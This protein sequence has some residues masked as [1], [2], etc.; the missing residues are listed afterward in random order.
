MKRIMLVVIVV[1][2]AFYFVPV[3]VTGS[4]YVV[5]NGMA[6]V[7]MPLT[8]VKVF[9]ADE[10]NKALEFKKLD[11]I[12]NCSQLPSPNEMTQLELTAI[13]DGPAA[14]NQFLEYRKQTE[15]CST[16]SFLSSA[17]Y[18]TP[19]ETVVTDKDGKFELN[20]N[21]FG[22]VVLVADGKRLVASG[23][24]TYTWLGRFAPSLASF[25]AKLDLTNN[26]EI[27]S[28]TIVDIEL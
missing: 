19:I 3:T 26:N 20:V 22:K 15:A 17:E 24:E 11:Y 7:P 18:L 16:A 2:I 23:E 21:R 4:V 28:T 1:L 8:K 9:D 6:T 25:S 13:Q 27:S 14:I 12:T 10:F 5:T